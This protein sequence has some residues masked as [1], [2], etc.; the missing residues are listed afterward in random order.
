MWGATRDPQSKQNK[1]KISIHAPMWGATFHSRSCGWMIGFQSTLPCGERQK[2]PH[3]PVELICISI[4]A[5]MWGA[6]DQ[7]C[8]LCDIIGISIHAPMWG[9]TG[10]DLLDAEVNIIS[11]HAPMWGATS[12]L[13]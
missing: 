7:L 1:T 9:A 3:N 10:T 11:I 2:L 4:H 5:P 12:C 6:T 13:G 8:G